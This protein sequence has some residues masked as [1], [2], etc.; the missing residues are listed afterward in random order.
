MRPGRG[1]DDPPQGMGL[2]EPDI[3]PL[4]GP[5][6]HII[7]Q[8]RRPREEGQAARGQGQAPRA[9]C[10]QG[11]GRHGQARPRSGADPWRKRSDPPRRVLQIVRGLKRRRGLV[12]LGPVD[13]QQARLHRGPVFCEGMGWKGDASH[14]AS[15]LTEAA[16]QAGVL[17]GG[18][19]DDRGQPAMVGQGLEGR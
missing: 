15:R 14:D 16:E 3:A 7:G 11:G 12:A 1:Q 8:G 4:A 6:L 2:V 17:Q 13:H 18:Q 9:R 10:Q 5:G 19:G